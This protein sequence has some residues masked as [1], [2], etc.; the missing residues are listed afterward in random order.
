MNATSEYKQNS[1]GRV[2]LFR[3]FCEIIL[4]KKIYSIFFLHESCFRL[5]LRDVQ[6]IPLE[7]VSS[8]SLTVEAS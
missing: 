4:V 2:T 3:L 1:A 8:T 5:P 7:L 6:A